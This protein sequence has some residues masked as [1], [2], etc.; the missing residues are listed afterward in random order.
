MP[1]SAA[2][3]FALSSEREAIA[4]T[5]EWGERM[6]PGV[7]LRM[8]ILA[9]DRIPQR[10]LS[11]IVSPPIWP[12]DLVQAVPAAAADRNCFRLRLASDAAEA[13]SPRGFAAKSRAYRPVQF[14]T[15]TKSAGAE[16]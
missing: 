3:A 9:V 4:V 14:V 13:L 5:S 10:T 7:T 11:V 8:P 12:L 1:S 15:G 16:W 6:M 2:A